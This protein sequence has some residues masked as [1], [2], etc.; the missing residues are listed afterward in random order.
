[1]VEGRERNEGFVF[2]FLLGGMALIAMAVRVKMGL[3]SLTLCI[4]YALHDHVLV[5]LSQ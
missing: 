2:G 4:E 3:S 5:G 1:M